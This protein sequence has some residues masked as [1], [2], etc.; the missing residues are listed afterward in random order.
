MGSTSTK[1]RFALEPIGLDP[2]PS[3]TRQL[4]SELGHHPAAPRTCATVAGRPP[5]T[6]AVAPLLL[7]VLR[8]GESRHSQSKLKGARSCLP[9]ILSA[10]GGSAPGGYGRIIPVI[11]V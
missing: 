10:L 6:G 4:P 1:L 5:P 3:P 8:L 7:Q 2:G 11:Q 9:T